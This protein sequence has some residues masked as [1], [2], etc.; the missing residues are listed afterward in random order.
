[1]KKIKY[2][3]PLVLIPIAIPVYEFL[4]VTLFINIFGCACPPPDGVERIFGNNFNANHFRSVV[5]SIL[6]IIAIGFGG[7]NSTKIKKRRNAIIY[8]ICMCLINIP[9]AYI[10]ITANVWK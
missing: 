5:F 9:L 2:I 1:M 6:A 3:L 8:F 4:D 10:E 7:I